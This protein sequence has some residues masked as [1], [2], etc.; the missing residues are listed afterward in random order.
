MKYGNLLLF[1]LLIG[2]AFFAAC[3][4]G[5]PPGKASYKD[6]LHIAINA[7]PD[8]LDCSNTTA[9]VASSISMGTIFESLVYI[10]SDYSVSL[11]LAEDYTVSG[12]AAVHT[13]K[14]RR[15]VKFHNGQELKADDAAASLNRWIELYGTA[16]SMIG[17][18]RF[19]KIDDYTITLKLDHPLLY[20]NDLIATAINRPIIVPRSLIEGR[21]PTEL[22]TEFIGT[23]PYKFVEW[24]QDR[25]VLL[26]RFDD[27]IPYGTKG[28]YSGWGGYKE[29]LVKDVYF[30]IVSSDSTRVAGLQSGEYN[31]SFGIPYDNYELFSNDPGFVV[32]TT[33]EGDDA[34]VFNKNE[35]LASKAKFRQAVQA[36][37]NVEDI[38][39][40]GYANPAFFTVDSSYIISPESEWYTKAGS[41]YYNAHD[42]VKTAALLE[43]SGYRGEPFR[44]LVS[45][46]YTN[47]YNEAL[48]IEQQLK[49]LGINVELIVRD[50]AA[51]MEIRRDESRWDGFIT[52]LSVAPVPPLIIYLSATWAGGAKDEKLQQGLTEITNAR[53][54][55]A[56]VAKWVELQEYCL[57]EYVPVCKLGNEFRLEVSSAKAE[58]GSFFEGPHPWN[59]RVIE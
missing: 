35:G 7:A 4:N 48:V 15:G 49:A 46:D 37:L 29:A 10:N 3:G 38:L 1:P 56:A 44:L 47:F 11:E 45:S 24:A 59:I 19:E 50:W 34:L 33:P 26:T 22:L 25:Y 32:H 9:G 21:E 12:D 53:D 43:E 13:Y 41:Q 17:E 16:A 57:A 8:T 42:P 54:K 39:L 14:L 2:G 23:G 6:E 36:A 58:G 30:D 18:A 5:E 52:S 55:A 31:V 27:Y 40:G 20:L 28:V 51:F